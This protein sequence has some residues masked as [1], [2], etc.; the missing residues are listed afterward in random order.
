MLHDIIDETVISALAI[1]FVTAL[2]WF[3]SVAF[4]VWVY[5]LFAGMG[6]GGPRVGKSIEERVKDLP[7]PIPQAMARLIA[8]WAIKNESEAKNPRALSLFRF[9]LKASVIATFASITTGDIGLMAMVGSISVILITGTWLVESHE[10]RVNEVKDNVEERIASTVENALLRYRLSK[11]EP[12]DPP[13]T[14]DA[15]D[16]PKPPEPS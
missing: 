10:K 14:P 15:D 5:G 13:A 4:I 6:R 3:T 2:V 7:Q 9:I 1:G 8:S 11:Y 12:V 16:E